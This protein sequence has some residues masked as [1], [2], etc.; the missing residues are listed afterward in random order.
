MQEKNTTKSM[1]TFGQLRASRRSNG[2]RS[3]VG[4]TII[5]YLVRK[6]TVSVL[7]RDKGYM[8][9]YNPLPEEVPE[10]KALGNSG[11]QRVIFECIS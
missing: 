3:K 10:G 8:V 2:V 4:R 11:R 1:G 5:R 7:G 6:V 9:K